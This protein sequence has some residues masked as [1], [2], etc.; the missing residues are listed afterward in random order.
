MRV[1]L[2][3]RPVKPERDWILKRAYPRKTNK[4]SLMDPELCTIPSFYAQRKF[5]LS[6]LTTE[7]QI[8]AC[9]SPYRDCRPSLSHICF[10]RFWCL[11]VSLLWR[12]LWA[13]YAVMTA[14]TAPELVYLCCGCYTATLVLLL[15]R[16]ADRGRSGWHRSCGSTS[17]WS[18]NSLSLSVFLQ[19]KAKTPNSRPDQAIYGCTMATSLYGNIVLSPRCDNGLSTPPATSTLGGNLFKLKIYFDDWQ[20]L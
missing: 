17:N 18:W 20:K 11:S 3:I 4:T 5:L 16:A 9:S 19:P 15:L 10:G 14:P 6:P 12:R 1:R 2:R 13:I 8:M 7:V